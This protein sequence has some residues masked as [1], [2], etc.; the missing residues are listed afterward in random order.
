DTVQ[1]RLDDVERMVA[2]GDLSEAESMA[3]QAKQSLDTVAG[4]LEAALDED[5]KSKWAAATQDALDG[6][7]RA[8][9]VA[10]DL[11]DQLASLSPKPDQ[12]M[13]RD[14]QQALERLR[15]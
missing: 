10:N 9:P 6:V 8:T 12:I 5:P 7:S 3:K 11:I 1:R 4:E 2:D 15:R 14:D 13:S